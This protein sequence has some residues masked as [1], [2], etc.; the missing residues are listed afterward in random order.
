VFGDADAAA[1]QMNRAIETIPSKTMEALT[2]YSWPGNTRELQNLT[3]RAVILS[4]GPVLEVP[5]RD[6]R[7]RAKHQT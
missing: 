7:S 5:P 2:R 4:S 6:L 1:R 3:E